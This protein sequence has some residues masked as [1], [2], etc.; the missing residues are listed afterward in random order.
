MK[1][2]WK[3]EE[4][5]EDADEYGNLKPYYNETEPWKNLKI[6][7]NYFLQFLKIMV[8]IVI[9]CLIVII[10]S[11]YQSFEWNEYGVFRQIRHLMY[12]RG[13]M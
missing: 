6:K 11:K 10:V 3:F 9:F 4:H 13:W 8:A 2:K 5:N 7:P 1:I 12:Q